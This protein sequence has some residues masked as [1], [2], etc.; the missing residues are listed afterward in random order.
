MI[1][2]AG[3]KDK[4]Q[5]GYKFLIYILFSVFFVGCQGAKKS[6]PNVEFYGDSPH[7]YFYEDE[8]R[9]V[10]RCPV[11]GESLEAKTEKC[12]KC[13][14]ELDWTGNIKDQFCNGS[15]ICPVCQG[16]KFCKFCGGTGK[17]NGE[18]CFNCQG[19]GIC[20]LCKGSG[21]CDKCG[22][23]GIY[24]F[25]VVAQ[26]N[27]VEKPI[28][29]EG[30]KGI[31]QSDYF[32]RTGTEV[33][34]SI[35]SSTQWQVFQF[36]DRQRVFVTRSYGEVLVFAPRE[37]GSY[38]I[39]VDNADFRETY[40]EAIQ[41][42]KPKIE[43]KS[44][45]ENN[46]VPVESGIVTD[47]DVL[48]YTTVVIP[49]MRSNCIGWWEGQKKI[50][51]G[52][53][54]ETMAGKPGSFGITADILGNPKCRSDFAS[55]IAIGGIGIKNVKKIFQGREE[56]LSDGG[57]IRYGEK[58]GFEGVYE[59]ADVTV[60]KVIWEISDGKKRELIKGLSGEFDV[61]MHGRIK[62]C[63][64]LGSAKPRYFTLNVIDSK[65]ANSEGNKLTNVMFSR[66]ENAFDS[67]GKLIENFYSYD[68]CAFYIEII[69]PSERPGETLQVFTTDREG[70]IV[71]KPVSYKIIQKD[72]KLLAGPIILVSDDVDDHY[73]LG[74]ITDDETND[75]TIKGVLGGKVNIIYKGILCGDIIIGNDPR[76]GKV[77]SISKVYLNF[78]FLKDKTGK[79]LVA[80]P[81]TFVKDLIRQADMVF[82]PAGINFGIADK[83]IVDLPLLNTLFVSGTASGISP[84]GGQG[85][86]A[87]SVNSDNIKYPTKFGEPPSSVAQKLSELL[88]SG[89]ISKIV[90]IGLTGATSYALVLSRT[91][92]IPLKISVE[93]TY[94]DTGCY[95]HHPVIDIA[96]G[97]HV[98]LFDDE[99]SYEEFGLIAGLKGSDSTIIDVIITDRMTYYQDDLYA[100]SYPIGVFPAEIAN[101]ILLVPSSREYPFV[102]AKHIAHLLLKSIDTAQIKYNLMAKEDAKVNTINATKRLTY[103]QMTQMRANFG[104]LSLIRLLRPE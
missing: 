86:L 44:Q 93:K 37:P 12:P 27:V 47:T 102:F 83:K 35:D 79:P 45:D 57:V 60:D 36:K 14:T 97:L 3:V 98:S 24:S 95:L 64:T 28:S 66:W 53:P 72:G 103:A 74:N 87:F 43:R 90:S 31:I 19:S 63:F 75:P 50:G 49:K 81:D 62:I 70:Q 13:N 2:L 11:C 30:K 67:Q 76:A 82:S 89:V 33:N 101:T 48:R 1:I 52:N 9:V 71:N 20:H 23:S 55:Y 88:P 4:R 18:M 6:I 69:D 42:L 78:V 68:P 10:V 91:G 17:L 39:S 26:T 61:N 99:V 77:D 84:E 58:I 22:G 54:L 15:G 32:V 5:F 46:F 56:K 100:R 16:K 59:P 38:V 104:F 29:K 41:I 92:D 80:Q 34:F 40:L 94:T 65:F 8:R 21:R 96:K 73:P 85:Y 25:S 51:I 7:A